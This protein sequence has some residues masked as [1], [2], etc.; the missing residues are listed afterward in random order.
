MRDSLNVTITGIRQES[1]DVSTLYFV[2][3]FDFVAGQ[4]IS[5]YFDDLN[6]PEGKAYSLSSRPSDELASITIKDVGGPFSSRLCRLK[7]GDTLAISRAYGHF[8]PRTSRPLVGIAAGVGLSPVWSILASSDHHDHQ[9]HYGNKTDSHIVY[10]DELAKLE[11]SV[12]HYISRQATTMYQHG[13]MDIARITNRAEADAHYLICGSVDF[14]RDVFT[15]LEQSSV[16][17]SHIST[18]IFFEHS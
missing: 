7:A 9:L 13:R 15:K 5:V 12:T 14:V 10:H 4:Y 16:A 18:E 3:P 11:S 2:R 8:N 17:R 6:V 1:P